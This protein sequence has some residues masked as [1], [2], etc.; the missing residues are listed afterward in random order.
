VNGPAP[1]RGRHKVFLG[2][3]A[4]VGKTY[5]MLEEGHEYLE[6]GDD[7]V[8]G[9]LETHGREATAA[10]AAGLEVLPRRT[11]E[12]RGSQLE[13]MD[14]PGIITRAPA[15]CL[16]DELAHTNAP[17]V[18]HAKRYEDVEDVLAAGIHVV[19]TMNVQHLE[20]LN[21]LVTE[22]TGVR[23]RETVP[24]AV[25]GRA[26]DVVVVDLTPAELLERLRAGR[27]YPAERIGAALNGFFTIE[28]LAAL[29]EVALRQVAEAAGAH[30]VARVELG[31]RGR[32]V[33]ADA[34]SAA[35]AER[36]LALVRPRPEDQR[37]VRRA[38]R[39]AQRLGAPLD[40]LWVQ[41]TRDLGEEE[42][43][44]L[45]ALR[46]LCGLLGAEL[47]IV[48]SDDV[49]RAVR[50][51]AGEHGTTYVLLGSPA[52][53]RGIARLRDALP[54]RLVRALEGIDVRIVA[55]RARRDAGRDR[56]DAR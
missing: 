56:E 20:S 53:E 48:E 3:A 36:L 23:V 18:E 4:G 55:D 45:R 7:I 24:D 51:F 35:V 26:D 44:G 13:E 41:P 6:D 29:R 37:I 50:E 54:V 28:N 33:S 42:D 21:D 2:M 25:L 14:L 39:S 17:G 43:R 12:Y 9:V 34:A 22:L 32:S 1:E 49:P 19:S 30:R 5:A 47:H 46:R 11:V 38:W 8:V 16:I 10:R 40:V 15:V 31:T 27:I 52:R